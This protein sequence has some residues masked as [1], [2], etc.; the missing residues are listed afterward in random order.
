MTDR[1]TNRRN[2]DQVSDPVAAAKVI[3]TG[4]MYALDASGNAL[5]AGTNGAGRVRAVAEDRADNTDGNA[6][7]VIVAGRCGCFQFGN[8]TS[9]DALTRADIGAICYAVDDSTVSKTDSSGARKIAGAVF[10][11]DDGGVWVS[12]GPSAVGPTGPAGAPG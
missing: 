10:D 5:P 8:S 9:T 3:S 11:V 4:T 2:A 1:N 12:I 7:D 6:G